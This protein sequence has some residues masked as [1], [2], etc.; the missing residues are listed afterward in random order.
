MICPNCQK[1]IAEGSK[2]CYSCGA[3]QQQAAGTPPPPY[4]YQAAPRKRLVRSST[5]NKIGGVCGGLADYF[6]IDPM[7][8][9]LIWVVLFFCAGTGGLAY[10]IL[11]IVLPLAPTGVPVTSATIVS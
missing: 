9:R 1:D 8:I 11:W 3:A 6:D 2:F 10:I 7:I 5:D 4:A